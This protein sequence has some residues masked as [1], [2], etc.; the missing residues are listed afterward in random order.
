MSN[1][2]DNN[3]CKA[4]N[5]NIVEFRFKSIITILEE[6]RVNIMTRIVAKRNQWSSWK[7]NYGPLIKKKFNDIKKEGVD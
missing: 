4:F 3:L 1:I 2:V 6:I 5:S 7:Y